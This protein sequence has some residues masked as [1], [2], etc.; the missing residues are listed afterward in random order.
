M[1]ASKDFLELVLDVIA[2]SNGITTT[3]I[4]QRL[5]F[6]S[7]YVHQ[8]VQVLEKEGRISRGE[9]YYYNRLGQEVREQV[10]HYEAG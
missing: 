3:R 6:S 8:A 4:A 1:A 9:G 5:D 10:W 2:I 7:Q